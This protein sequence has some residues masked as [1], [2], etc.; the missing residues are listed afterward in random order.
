VLDET[1]LVENY[2]GE[3][4]F[5]MFGNNDK[6]VDQSAISV[7]GTVS[8]KVA[9]PPRYRNERHIRSTLPTWRTARTARSLR[10][11]EARTTT[12]C[13]PSRWSVEPEQ[14][15]TR[16]SDAKVPGQLPPSPPRRGAGMILVAL[17]G[18][19]LALGGCAVGPKYVKPEV[20]AN[21][22][23]SEKAD[24]RLA[25]GTAPASTWWKVFNDATL[26][27]L[28]ELAHR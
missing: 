7:V 17:A 24:P 21:S 25:T 27:Q 20:S 10:P 5:P 26:D 1:G 4:T 12:G 6:G 18:S 9:R 16:M 13:D 8:T 3:G 23:W 19:V 11:A 14:G 28:V 15:V 22:D 2:Q